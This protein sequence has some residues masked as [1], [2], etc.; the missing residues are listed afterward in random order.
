L[1]IFSIWWTPSQ[2][3]KP[4]YPSIKF[5]LIHGQSKQCLMDELSI[6]CPLE[7]DFL[8]FVYERSW[9][10]SGFGDNPKPT[11]MTKSRSYM[12]KL[13]AKIHVFSKCKRC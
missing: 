3:V 11:S 12:V 6:L 13:H 9:S 2:K 8:S 10:S 5:C 1:V 7:Y 4:Y